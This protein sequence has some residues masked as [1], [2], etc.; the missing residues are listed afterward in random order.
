MAGSGERERADSMTRPSTWFD[1]RS[2]AALRHRHVHKLAWMAH[3]DCMQ[4]Y[5]EFFGL[6]MAA[7][8]FRAQND[9]YFTL[10]MSHKYHFY[11]VCN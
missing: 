4:R 9:K 8:K 5:T 11:Q 7:A 3:R 6:R 10:I 2:Q 1:L